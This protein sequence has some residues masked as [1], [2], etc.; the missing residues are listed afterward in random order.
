MNPVKR[1]ENTSL[2]AT[3]Y[4]QSTRPEVSQ[5]TNMEQTCVGTPVDHSPPDNREC[6]STSKLKCE[7][8]GF[9]AFLKTQ[10]PNWRI[11]EKCCFTFTLNE[12][13]RKSDR[14]VFTASGELNDNIYS[15]LTANDDFCQ[16]M[17][18]NM[19][20]FVYEDKTI[21]GYVNLGM[22]L[23]C[24]PKDSHFTIWV[25][26]RKNMKETDQILRQCENPD[27]E[28]ILFHIEAIGEIIKKIVKINELHEKATTLCVYAPK[29][30][31]VKE[32]LCKDGRFR[33]DLD[34][35]EWELKEG[36]KN[37]YGK[38]TKVEHVSGKT[39]KMNIYKKPSVKSTPTKIK[40]KNKSATHEISP[41]NQN[42][43]WEPE[44]DGETEDVE[45]S[46]EKV[47]PPQSLRHNS[48]K[49]TSHYQKNYKRKNRE[50]KPHLAPCKALSNHLLG[51][52]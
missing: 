42:Q 38:Q 29:G 9:E 52:A 18:K 41:Q 15:A 13:S 5:D 48:S 17:G 50:Q 28:C 11:S 2:S 37:I 31:T 35:R 44:I 33:V 21:E 7:V 19:D 24:L 25:V 23:K 40:Q 4:D 32:A 43:I 3:E 16:R 36:C 45:H 51:D 14:S 10:N 6:S 1:E 8:N 20:I 34:Q 27:T 12:S 47:S 49:I 30:E 26:R 22:P 46:Q 39:L